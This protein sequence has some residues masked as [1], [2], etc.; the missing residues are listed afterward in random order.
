MP[1]VTVHHD[2]GGPAYEGHDQTTGTCLTD[3][4]WAAVFMQKAKCRAHFAAGTRQRRPA[5]P[6]AA[7][8]RDRYS[9][10][11]TYLRVSLHM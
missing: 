8:L 6:D 3:L 1:V 4:P 7:R 10:P 2:H 11:F 5:T 9:R